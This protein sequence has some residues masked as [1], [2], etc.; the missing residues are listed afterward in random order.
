MQCISHGPSHFRLCTLRCLHVIC[1]FSGY[2]DDVHGY[3]FV[4]KGSPQDF[5]GHGTHIA[6]IIAASPNNG[7]G[8]AGIAPNVKIMCLKASDEEPCPYIRHPDWYKSP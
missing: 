5:Y 2:V 4:G 6:G 7:I 8:V 1:Y 3:D